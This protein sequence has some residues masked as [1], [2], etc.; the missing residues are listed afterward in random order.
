LLYVRVNSVGSVE[1][2]KCFIF[3]PVLTII[4]ETRHR[5]GL[6][7]SAFYFDVIKLP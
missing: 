1:G 7:K 6:V 3:L 2:V 5:L 4:Y